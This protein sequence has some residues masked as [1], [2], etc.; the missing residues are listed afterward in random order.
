MSIATATRSCCSRQATSAL[1]V[2]ARCC[3]VHCYICIY[4]FLRLVLSQPSDGEGLF[5]CTGLAFVLCV[6]ELLEY[7]KKPTVECKFTIV[8][9]ATLVAY[10][11]VP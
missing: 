2:Q 3:G 5:C 8:V 4:M 1:V 7:H 11:R 9:T 6:V 10:R